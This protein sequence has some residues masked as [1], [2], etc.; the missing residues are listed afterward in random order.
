MRKEINL[1]MVE[2]SFTIN[3]NPIGENQFRVKV[4]DIDNSHE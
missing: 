1:D 3:I 2:G 4:F